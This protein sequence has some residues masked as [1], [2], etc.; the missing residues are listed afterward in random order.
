M[1][2]LH[3][4]V[5]FIEDQSV[6]AGFD[7]S[8]TS[9]IEVAVEEAL[10]NIIQ[11]GDAGKKGEIEISCEYQNDHGL[12]I[13]I[14]DKGIAYD[15]LQKPP[16]TTLDPPSV[17]GYGIYLIRKIMDK[18]TYHREGEYNVLTLYKSM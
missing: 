17:G 11:Y 13:T 6:M 12:K 4:M 8:T 5:Q 1:N 7:S 9:K 2:N 3:K 15:P 18:V 14:K 10:V 16:L